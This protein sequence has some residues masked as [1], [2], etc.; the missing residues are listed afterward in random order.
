MLES[1]GL[2][3]GEAEILVRSQLE[4]ARE[5][6]VFMSLLDRERKDA[7]LSRAAE[8]ILDGC[9]EILEVNGGDVERAR[10]G[11]VSGAKIKRLT[12]DR[13]R[14]EGGALS[15]HRVKDLPDPVGSEIDSWSRPNGM[16]VRRVR[17]PIG[18][19]GMI[20]ES[21]PNVTLDVLGLCAKSGNGVMLRPGSDCASSARKLYDLFCE[22]WRSAGLE[23]G[24]FVMVRS[25]DRAFV[26]G[27]LRAQGLLDVV[28]PRGGE[29]LVSR[30]MAE[31]RVP[32]FGHLSGLCHVYV[33]GGADVEK[34][35]ALVENGKMRSPAICGATETVLV[36][37]VL[38]EEFVPILVDRMVGLGCEVRGCERSREWVGLDKLGIAEESDWSTEYLE[39]VLSLKVVDGVEGAISHVNMYGSGHTDCI[40][41][42][43][44]PRALKF[45]REVKSAI[46]MH[47]VSTQF[48]DGGE[49]GLG[50]EMGIATGRLHARGPV[51]LEQ[52]TTMQYR[53]E[54]EGQCR[55]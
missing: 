54:G 29:G 18:M 9:D 48:A 35:L 45:M 25:T 53:V 36:D 30:V 13:S 31:S 51:G 47:N 32:V 8:C 2:K 22:G 55:A 44:K 34:A 19:V 21:R 27:M 4:R 37:S 50:A 15:L 39:A 24:C 1:K 6:L 14:V 40:V 7:G 10:E 33:D 42:E 16:R 20:Y 41:S 12:L 23:A 46:A 26:G 38:A 3:E 43:D 52:M 28:I 5:G 17:V 11:G 49:L